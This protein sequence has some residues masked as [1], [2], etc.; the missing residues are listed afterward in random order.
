M[1]PRVCPWLFKVEDQEQHQIREGDA[2]QSQVLGPAASDPSRFLLDEGL[3]AVIR[4][5]PRRSLFHIANSYGWQQ[6]TAEND[7]TALVS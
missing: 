4:S 2:V 3:A 5:M 6:M 1:T 7:S